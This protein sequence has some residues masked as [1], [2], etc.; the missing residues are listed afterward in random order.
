PMNPDDIAADLPAPRDDEPA[1]LRQDIVDELADHLQCALHRELLAGGEA[2]PRRESG[3]SDIEHTACQHPQTD[4]WGSPVH[5]WQ[6]VLT[7]F[8]NPATIARRLWFDAMKE[9]LMAQRITAIMAGLTAAAAIVIAVLVWQST[10]RDSDAQQQLLLAQ[11][12]LNRTLLAEL[13]SLQ[14]TSS[15]AA[16]TTAGWAPVKVRLQS[17]DG[18]PVAG[19]VAIQGTA[20]NAGNDNEINVTRT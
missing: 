1:S 20:I 14:Q 10:L 9:R 2:S 5:A 3:D 16:A 13:K 18:K 19:S 11:Q 15:T 6:R 12:E 4:V 17:E 7:R 8:G